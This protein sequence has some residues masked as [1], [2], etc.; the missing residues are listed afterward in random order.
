MNKP[1]RKNSPFTIAH[2]FQ[3]FGMSNA[4]FNRKAPR[5]K[6]RAPKNYPDHV[7]P[8]T[9]KA[10][11]LFKKQDRENPPEN[12]RQVQRRIDRPWKIKRLLENI[13]N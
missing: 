6:R 2:L 7:L 1:M 13:S 11:N 8:S 3:M 10:W 4:P 9:R 5:S 12:S